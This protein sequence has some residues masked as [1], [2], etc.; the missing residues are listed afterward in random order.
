VWT[1]SAAVPSPAG[2]GSFRAS[3]TSQ[4]SPS[5]SEVIANG[6]QVL[7]TADNEQLTV[8]DISN[9]PSPAAIR[10]RMLARLRIE[11]DDF[12]RCTIYKSHLGASPDQEGPR[13][14]DAEL[15]ELCHTPRP[16]SDL[17]CFSVH[18]DEPPPLRGGPTR[19]AARRPSSPESMQAADSRRSS[20]SL[21]DAVQGPEEGSVVSPVVGQPRYH[22]HRRPTADQLQDVSRVYNGSDQRR[23][24]VV[25]TPPTPQIRAEP[26][27]PPSH[28][29]R[30]RAR[31]AAPDE[32][33]SASF[34]GERPRL[35]WNGWYDV[36]RERAA[37][38]RRNVTA[39]GASPSHS[40]LGPIQQQNAFYPSSIRGQGLFA[41]QGRDAPP[42]SGMQPASP[43]R[44]PPGHP[45]FYDGHYQQDHH[46]RPRPVP[47]PAPS[48]S[49]SPA[50]Y[51]RRVRPVASAGDMRRHV[52]P[53]PHNYRV[54][55]HPHNMPPGPHP[56]SVYMR[57][58]QQYAPNGQ[59][60]PPP[61]PRPPTASHHYQPPR[62]QFHQGRPGDFQRPPPQSQPI[63]L[64]YPYVGHADNAPPF[65]TVQSRQWA[66][67]AP[68]GPSHGRPAP[69]PQGGRG[70]RTMGYPQE[71]DYV[72]SQAHRL[73]LQ[74]GEILQNAIAHQ[75]TAPKPSSPA[76]PRNQY[77]MPWEVSHDRQDY[78][79][80]SQDRYPSDSV[81]P[82]SP[83]PRVP[84]GSN[85]YHSPS[86]SGSSQS[87]TTRQI[88]SVLRPG[89]R[90]PPNVSERPSSL[91]S[92]EASD[93]LTPAS[94]ITPSA[95]PVVP[96]A[97]TP[98]A[99]VLWE[100]DLIQ[101][102]E[103][104][105]WREE[106]R[107]TLRVTNANSDEG[108]DGSGT[109][110]AEDWVRLVAN[111]SVADGEGTLRQTMRSEST[112]RPEFRS[113]PAASTSELP[114]QS[115]SLDTEFGDDD[116]DDDFDDEAVTW[117]KPLKPLVPPSPTEASDETVHDS[118]TSPS[119][120]QRSP[121][122]QGRKP[123]LAPLKMPDD[124]ATPQ[125]PSRSSSS[126]R[127]ATV[128]PS[129]ASSRKSDTNRLRPYNAHS[130]SSSSSQIT[131]RNSFARRDDNWAFRPPVEQV[132]ENL[133]E[134][135]PNHDLDKPIID[136]TP[137][138]SG[139]PS[140]S[141]GNETSLSA[142][143]TSPQ[144]FRHK[145]SI[146]IVAQDRKRLLQKSERKAEMGSSGGSTGLLRRKSTKMWGNRVEEVA[147]GQA[148]KTRVGTIPESPSTD[149]ENCTPA[150]SRR[151]VGFYLLTLYMHSLV[152]VGQG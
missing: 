87:S 94:D 129:S 67:P 11:D 89:H 7:V 39:T 49:L 21:Q 1:Q 127:T 26:D 102:P 77:M 147:P 29:G 17:L 103:A 22:H 110:H 112:P 141:P 135:F 73:H 35:Q 44:A 139:S 59:R 108:D 136:A 117:A 150:I 6:T 2:S 134:F 9:L 30:P 41:G 84:S 74:P 115:H 18:I 75:S 83:G 111:F 107:T 99:P 60:P 113:S 124:P 61:P 122:I 85:S 72:H 140:I 145:K 86:H 12:P 19:Q 131:R 101:E 81:Q 90:E 3:Q 118:P 149:P 126:P 43:A 98:T 91:S 45:G 46:G 143:G 105:T 37:A 128:E 125:P 52:T 97:P 15:W 119:T 137:G 63:P 71:S 120:L 57:E 142:K 82:G 69:P 80:E 93:V 4:P 58:P 106:P 53:P 54:P 116:F 27:A 48:L 33:R 133:E 88:P 20:R 79:R 10:E 50:D 42:M 23:I 76:A 109:V 70:V 62:P 123:T 8:V 38:V 32:P 151:F 78:S 146:R 65:T 55:V 104:M 132:Y 56:H 92:N 25:Q 130:S 14:D 47:S 34:E 5:G 51:H 144:R 28:V 114:L 68:S 13:I 95:P 64:Y 66:V 16:K 40:A 36:E 31:T 100:D 121:A 96:K 152:Q 138:S 24:S 148:V